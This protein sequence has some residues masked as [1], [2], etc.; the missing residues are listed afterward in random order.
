[1]LTAQSSSGASTTAKKEEPSR[2]TKVV[3]IVVVDR[4]GYP[5]RIEVAKGASKELNKKAV[6]AIK[7]W[8]FEPAKKNG[9]PVAV[10]ISVEINFKCS[11]NDQNCVIQPTKP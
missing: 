2:I 3:L 8:K 7:K 11:D 6:D 9:E 1:L 10:K 4:D 5:G